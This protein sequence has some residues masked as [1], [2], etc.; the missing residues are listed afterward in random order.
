M[1]KNVVKV[2]DNRSLTSNP[3]GR[4]DAEGTDKSQGRKCIADLYIYIYQK[5]E[6][7]R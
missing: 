1:K 7:T 5:K 6:F 3:N 4:P 2:M